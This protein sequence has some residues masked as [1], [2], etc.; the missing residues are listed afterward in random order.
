MN[1]FEPTIQALNIQDKPVCMYVCMYVCMGYSI[2][3]KI[4]SYDLGFQKAS[5]S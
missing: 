5:N 1:Y 4:N 3:A 2:Y